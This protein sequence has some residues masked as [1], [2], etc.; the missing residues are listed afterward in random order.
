MNIIQHPSHCNC[1]ACDY[2]GFK[3]SGSKD[4]NDWWVAFPDD[5]DDAYEVALGRIHTMKKAA[6][7]TALK[8]LLTP[9]KPW[10]PYSPLMTQFL[11]GKMG[12]LRKCGSQTLRD[13]WA[14]L[15]GKPIGIKSS[16]KLMKSDL[17]RHIIDIAPL[18]KRVREDYRALSF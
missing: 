7:D 2:I 8:A 6:Y 3:D 4:M 15:V 1:D 13:L 5:D 17:I 11:D 18:S 12:D 16:G 9:P 10:N 14:E